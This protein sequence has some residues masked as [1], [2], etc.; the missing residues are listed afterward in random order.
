MKIVS[1]FAVFRV[2]EMSLRVL[3]TE[4]PNM[5]TCM[6]NL[7]FTWKDGVRHHETVTLMEECVR[8]QTRVVGVDHKDKC[9]VTHRVSGLK[10]ETAVFS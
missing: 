1:E 7:T 8:L 5:L 4:H 9:F 3:G 10:G 6:N 2:M